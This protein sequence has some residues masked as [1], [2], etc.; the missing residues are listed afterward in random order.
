MATLI[1][2]AV[3]SKSLVTTH[4][5]V[6]PMAQKLG[7]YTYSSVFVLRHPSFLFT[8]LSF[9]LTRCQFFPVSFIFIDLGVFS[10]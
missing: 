9:Y 8:P 10:L 1:L 3:R 7:H 2:L 6:K 5:V 4:I